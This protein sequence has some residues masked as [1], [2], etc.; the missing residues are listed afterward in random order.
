MATNKELIAAA[1]LIKENC[2][3]SLNLCGECKCVFSDTKT[4]C[5]LKNVPA[6][7]KIPHIKTRK[8]VMVEKFPDANIADLVS[9]VCPSVFGF[10]E[11]DMNYDCNNDCN[12]C[13][14]QPAESERTVSGNE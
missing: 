3:N 9:S 4:K 6:Y 13:W 5:N 12:Q 7:F 10:G 8:E 2:D 11:R 14:N 1:K